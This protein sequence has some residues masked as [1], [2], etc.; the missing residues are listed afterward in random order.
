MSTYM[1]THADG[2][3]GMIVN[4]S[5]NTSLCGI[6]V[7]QEDWERVFGKNDH[8]RQRGYKYRCHFD[9]RGKVVEETWCEEFDGELTGCRRITVNDEVVE[10]YEGDQRKV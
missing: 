7:S 1:G 2:S 3:R 6:N 5:E 8:S 9:R 10:F 4:C